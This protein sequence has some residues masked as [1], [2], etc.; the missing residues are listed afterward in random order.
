MISSRT[1]QFFN[2]IVNKVTVLWCENPYRFQLE[3]TIFGIMT[4]FLINIGFTGDSIRLESGSSYYYSNSD[5][6]FNRNLWILSG[7][8]CLE[9][10]V[11]ISSYQISYAITS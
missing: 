10:F 5:L 8:N 7:R 4:I 6:K 2:K 11:K 1:V 3:D 9:T